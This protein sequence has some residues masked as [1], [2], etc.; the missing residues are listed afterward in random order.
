MNN[1]ITDKAKTGD[2]II[3]MPGSWNWYSFLETRDELEKL[4][5]SVVVLDRLNNTSFKIVH[6]KEMNKLGWYKNV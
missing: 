6:E 5:Y 3:L 4:G 1:K 2:F